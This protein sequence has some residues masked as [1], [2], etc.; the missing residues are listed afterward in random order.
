MKTQRTQSETI[1]NEE[2]GCSARKVRNNGR[3]VI[4][5]SLYPLLRVGQVNLLPFRH[6]IAL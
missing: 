1:G 4:V 6:D 2:Q 3:E 5:T